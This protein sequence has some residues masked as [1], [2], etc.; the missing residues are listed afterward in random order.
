[1]L[2]GR[3]TV[4]VAPLRAASG[5]APDLGRIAATLRAGG[6]A[7]VLH[8]GLLRFGAEGVRV[9]VFPDGRA[10]VEGT[11]DPSRARAVYDRWIGS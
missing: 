4:Q 11:D 7:V 2:C 8:E 5:G 3:N 1:V 10:L 9:T 6:C